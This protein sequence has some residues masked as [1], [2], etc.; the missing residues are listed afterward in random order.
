MI[1]NPQV[2][3]KEGI[4]K[5]VEQDTKYAKQSGGR[6]QYGHVVITV[7]PNELG[8]GFEFENKIVGGVIQRSISLQ[9]KKVLK[10][11]H[12]MESSQGFQ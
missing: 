3:Y 10:K 7:E 12:K 1:G 11:Q 4:T 9:L 2:S 6:G 8:K 5:S